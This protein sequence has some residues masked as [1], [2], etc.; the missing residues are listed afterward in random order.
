[1]NDGI[2]IGRDKLTG[3]P[4]YLPFDSFGVHYHLVGATGKGKTTFLIALLAGLLCHPLYRRVGVFILDRMGGFSMAIKRFIASKYC[5]ESVRRRFL[6]IETANEDRVVT[7]Y[8]FEHRTEAELNF[9]VDHATELVVRGLEETNIGAM[10]RFKLWTGHTFQSD[11]ALRLSL[12]DSQYFLVRGPHRRRLVEMLPEHLRYDWLEILD[13]RGSQE[14]TLLESS[15]NRLRPFWAYKIPRAQ[16]GSTVNRMDVLHWL[17]SGAIVLVDLSPQ[18]RVSDHMAD[19]QAGMI[20]NEILST[21][22][23]LPPGEVYKHLLILDEF[24]RYIG[25]DIYNAIPEMRQKGT[26][27]VFSHQSFSQLEHN[28]YDLTDLIFQAQ[29]RVMFGVGGPDAAILAEEIASLK[30]NPKLLKDEIRHRSQRVVGHQVVELTG[31]ARQTSDGTSWG[32]KDSVTYA[33]GGVSLPTRGEGT[34]HGG[35][36]TNGETIST[37]EHLVPLH[38]EFEQ[39]ASRNYYT[40]DEQKKLIEK[41]LRGKRP[42]EADIILAND[43]G[44]YDVEVEAFG[45]GHLRLDWHEV[46]RR[47]P[48][49]VDEYLAF[50]D[51]NFALPCFV[52]PEQ[53]EL[54][55]RLRL[56]E[57]LQPR[58]ELL[59]DDPLV[60]NGATREVLMTVEANPM[61]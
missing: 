5:P 50:L 55:A 58:I 27:C 54:E 32:D 36:R 14:M 29:N 46:E 7:L 21:V 20:L 48:G 56:K 19:C 41:E 51:R 30:Y 9:R 22:R 12:A 39:V 53:V 26:G 59:A 49:V 6:C 35:S 45:P 61:D 13:A 33:P 34:Q 37:S 43:S 17:R 38:E 2:Q 1:M 15:R 24:Q 11:A 25:P 44:V 57:L 4:F 42:G 40:F 18:G 52:S 10:P 3:R 47:L 31:R 8:P 16:F 60:I 28:G 23:S